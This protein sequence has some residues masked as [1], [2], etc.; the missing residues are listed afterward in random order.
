MKI[1]NNRA[2]AP[3]IYRKLES[4]YDAPGDALIYAIY[5]DN[6][7]SR[8]GG[9]HELL[10]AEEDRKNGLCELFIAVIEYAG[11]QYDY[12]AAGQGWKRY[13]PPAV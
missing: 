9:W 6:D 10:E 11:G 7:G 3:F 2:T 8:T 1:R 5:P 12:Y 13:A 4:L